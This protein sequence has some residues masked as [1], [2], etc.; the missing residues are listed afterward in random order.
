MLN[1]GIAPGDPLA[2]FFVNPVAYLTEVGE[3]RIQQIVFVQAAGPDD[4]PDEDDGAFDPDRPIEPG[5][6]ERPIMVKIEEGDPPPEYDDDPIKGSSQTGAK[7]LQPGGRIFLPSLWE[8]IPYNDAK[9][10]PMLSKHFVK[11]AQLFALNFISKASRRSVALKLLK[12]LYDRTFGTTAKSRNEIS[13]FL[14]SGPVS[15]RIKLSS[16]WATHQVCFSNGHENFSQIYTGDGYLDTSA[17]FDALERFYKGRLDR[18]GILQVMHHGAKGNWHSGIANKLHPAVSIFSS[19]P[20]SPTTGLPSKHPN[21]DVLRDFWPWCPVQ[22]DCK[23]SFHFV[24]HL[25]VL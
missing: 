5:D 7:F 21:A 12:R 13:L 1:E 6:A 4:T 17:R 9:Q 10:M 22:V 2:Q 16:F 18:M 15:S 20:I 19:N 24:G 14:Y 11:R 25:Y 8:F 23:N 3:G